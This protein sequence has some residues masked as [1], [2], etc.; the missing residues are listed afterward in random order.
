MPVGNRRM[1]NPIIT[2]S[3]KFLMMPP[4]TQALY[5]H[6]NTNADDDGV[7]EAYSVMR[8]TGSKE[9]DM[10]ILIA[11]KFAT[12][13]DPDQQ[14]VWINHWFDHNNIRRDIL[15]ESV[16]R[17]LLVSIFPQ[18]K[19]PKSLRKDA[20]KKRAERK[21]NQVKSSVTETL[22]IRNVADTDPRTSIGKDSIDKDSLDN[23]P[24]TPL[25]GEDKE[26]SLSL[27]NKD[28]W[29]YWEEN[30]A[31]ITRNLIFNRNALSGLRRKHGPD[32]VKKLIRIAAAAHSEQFVS[33]N[34][35][36]SSPKQLEQQWDALVL[37]AKGKTTQIQ[38]NHFTV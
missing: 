25:K 38:S 3:G 34:L 27:E 2:E 10:A 37:W 20:N 23:N 29:D 7:V 28:L 15:V 16:H 33:K 22:R 11:K 30:L 12:V 36:V 31:P 1:I 18:L 13:L 6:L 19:L 5:F 35:K 21:R 32:T 8:L 17:E 9:D 4:S 24:P 14:L 26:L